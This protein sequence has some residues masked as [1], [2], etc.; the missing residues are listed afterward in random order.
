MVAKA[1]SSGT[2]TPW[3]C[4][5]VYARYWQHYHQAMA[6]MRS[7]LNAYRKAV[8]SYFSSP[9]YFTPGDLPQSSPAKKGGSPQAFCDHHLAS[10]SSCG[11]SHSPR[12]GHHPHDSTS[13][14]HSWSTEEATETNSDAGEQDDLSSMEITEELR[15]YFAETERHREERRRQQHLDAQHLEDYV[16]ADHDLYYKTGRSM[17]LPSESPGEWCQAEMKRLYGPWRPPCS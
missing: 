6:W 12:S 7:H 17:E 3:S 14:D 13:E 4:H 10:Q 1:A 16:D 15:Q 5:P 9:W 2:T 8:K 11:Y